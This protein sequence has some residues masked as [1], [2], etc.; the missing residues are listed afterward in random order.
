[1]VPSGSEWFGKLPKGSE[2]LGRGSGSFRSLRN[3]HAYSAAFAE[4]S[5][6]GI[7][8]ISASFVGAENVTF[9]A[10]ATEC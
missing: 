4:F 2:T 10:I 9:W 5:G 3:H 8:M 7:W 6:R 1:M